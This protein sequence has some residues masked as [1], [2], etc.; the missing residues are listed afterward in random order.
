MIN[1]DNVRD[2][3]KKY[4]TNNNKLLENIITNNSLSS[5]SNVRDKCQSFSAVYNIEVKPHLKVT[6]QKSS[7]RC[8]LFAALN[9]LR[10]DVCSKYKLDNFEISQSYLF[11][12]DKLERMNYNL[13]CIIRTKNESTDSQ[14]IQHLLSDPTCDGGQWDMVVN[15]INKYGLVPKSVYQE[16]HHSSSSRELNTILK[17]KFR[18]YAYSLRNSDNVNELKQQYLCETYDV[19]CKFLGTPPSNF[20]WEF[21]NKNKEYNKFVNLTPTTFYKDYVDTNVEDYVCVVNDPR[22]EHPYNKIYTVKYLGNVMDGRQVKYLNVPIN[23]L[24]ELTL[25]SLKNN[26]SVWFGCDVGQSLNRDNCAMDLSQVNSLELFGLDFK[27]D[28]EQR[29]KYKDSLM[30]HAMVFTGANVSENDNCI[31]NQQVINGWEVEN[32]WSS[33][34]PND[35]YY[36]MSDSWFDEFVYEV[37]IHKDSLNDEETEILNGKFYKEL[38]P[39]DP[40][41]ALA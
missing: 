15:L 29:L 4:S 22:K 1:Q 33:R 21:I 37:A 3:Q 19:L 23:R 39:W 12:W 40:M 5:L 13:E 10:R 2:W 32:S 17:K 11:F 34:G 9:V 20:Q 38:Q 24:K 18:E 8:W 35:G 14:L 27:L 26:K 25:N 6:N 31:D 30:T 16:T 28:K 36:Y 7:G 41:G